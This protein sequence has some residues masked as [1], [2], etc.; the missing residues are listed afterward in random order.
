[1][2]ERRKFDVFVF[3]VRERNKSS[4][5]DTAS[6]A[7]L[8]KWEQASKHGETTSLET[9]QLNTNGPISQYLSSLA[10]SAIL[11]R[12]GRHGSSDLGTI[13]CIS[14]FSSGGFDTPSIFWFQFQLIIFRPAKHK[15][16]ILASWAKKDISGCCW[17]CSNDQADP[18]TDP[19]HFLTY[20][21]FI[22][23]GE[24]W[25]ISWPFQN[26]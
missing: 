22:F 19:N 17:N 3:L 2:F 6:Q 4:V 12:P 25:T 26:K 21:F 5:A 9:T 20:I 18:W 10:C 15:K 8:T 11:D 7:L 14:C 16:A 23:Y 24:P 1:M 13:S